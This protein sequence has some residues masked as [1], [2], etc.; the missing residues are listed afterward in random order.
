MNIHINNKLVYYLPLISK[1]GNI[2]IENK[3]QFF[4]KIKTIT[5]NSLLESWKTDLKKSFKI[6]IAVSLSLFYALHGDGAN[7][8]NLLRLIQQKAGALP[9]IEIMRCIL[10]CEINQFD[11]AL[12]IIKNLP[13]EISKM[14]FILRLKADIYFNI[15][16]HE[17][18]K[19]LYEKVFGNVSNESSIYSRLGEIYL[20]KNNIEKAGKLFTKAIKL[21]NKNI[22]AHFY[23]GDVYKLMGKNKTAKMEYGICAAIDFKN[24]FA[25]MAQQK[26]FLLC[27]EK[28]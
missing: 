5:R 16:E 25:I 28:R 11:D 23:L 10:Y 2:R 9:I 17:K 19:Q 24:E 15:D 3:G 18:A 12:Q 21:D 26:L 27:C 7:C 14:P 22:M 1:L 6:H 4:N 8:K 13:L 20:L